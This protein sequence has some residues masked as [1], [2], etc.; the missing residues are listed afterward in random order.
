MQPL[1]QRRPKLLAKMAEPP[2]PE[3]SGRQLPQQRNAAPGIAF[4]SAPKT[5][6]EACL[7]PAKAVLDTVVGIAPPT[8]QTTCTTDLCYRGDNRHSKSCLSAPSHSLNSDPYNVESEEIA[9]AECTRGV[10]VRRMWSEQEMV[11]TFGGQM[12]PGTPDGMFEAW[13]GTL[14]CVQVVRVPFTREMTARELQDVLCQIVV[15][16]V[17]KSQHWLH[18]THVVPVDFIVF[19]W[20]PFAISQAVAESADALME[21]IR[22]Q[23]PRFSLRL[24]VPA[25]AGALFPALFACSGHSRR[26]VG[27][28]SESDV[29]T[30]SGEEESDDDEWQWDITWWW[31]DDCQGA[32]RHEQMEEQ[33]EG[34]GGPSDRRMSDDDSWEAHTTPSQH[35]SLEASERIRYIWDDGG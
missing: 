29:S 4:V 35:A 17:V 24:R 28:Y 13:D 9:M 21:R 20:L 5:V 12:F 19:C 15:T 33:A 16:K 23:D 25:K 34:D 27:R 26:A 31:D 10:E 14:T 6:S 11:C 18:A 2:L 3:L 32:E 1:P 30:Y 22:K 8:P 7:L